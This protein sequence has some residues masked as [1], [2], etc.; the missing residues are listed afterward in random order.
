[1]RKPP[2]IWLPIRLFNHCATDADRFYNL[3]TGG[4]LMGY[5]YG[6]TAVIT[7]T[8]EAG[9]AALHQRYSFEPDQHWQVEQIARHYARSGR[10]ETYIGD[11]HTHPAA[12]SGRLS[13]TDRSVLR[14]IIA[15]PAARAPTPIMIVLHGA[16]GAW[17]ATAWVGAFKARRIFFSSLL[18]SK[19]T[20]RLHDLA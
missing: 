7:A 18:L 19:V 17:E 16:K 5:W 4:A 8:I 2:V 6:D 12:K 20:L 9:P 14:R 11:W 15:T 3:E 10:R 1:M 13:R